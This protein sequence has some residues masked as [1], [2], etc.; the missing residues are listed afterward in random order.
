MTHTVGQKKGIQIIS[1]F[2]ILPAS[3]IYSLPLSRMIILLSQMPL[4]CIRVEMS[5]SEFEHFLRAEVEY[6]ISAWQYSNTV[7]TLFLQLFSFLHRKKNS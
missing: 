3:R 5:D 1:E 6:S 4:A 2:I 7:L